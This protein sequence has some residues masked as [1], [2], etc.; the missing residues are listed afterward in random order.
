MTPFI[1][2]GSKTW[3]QDEP[4]R[5]D[6]WDLYWR[7]R[8]L[9]LA[10]RLDNQERI[11]IEL[12]YLAPEF[13]DDD[14]T[15][16][17]FFRARDYSPTS[18]SLNLCLL[19]IIARD[20][21]GPSAIASGD[22][23]SLLWQLDDGSTVQ[24]LAQLDVV[25]GSSSEEGD[26]FWYVWSSGSKPATPLFTMLDDGS[27]GVLKASPAYEV[28]ITGDFNADEYDNI[29]GWFL[30][31][32]GVIQT[33]V[34]AE[35]DSQWE[36]EI[37]TGTAP[38]QATNPAPGPNDNLNCDYLDGEDEWPGAG[39]DD[40]S[41]SPVTVGTSATSVASVTTTKAGWH[42][43]AGEVS[44]D[45]DSG[46]EDQLFTL[47]C[48]GLEELSVLAKTDGQV[49]QFH[50]S[51]WYEATSSEALTLTIKKAGGSGSTEAEGSLIADW[52][53]K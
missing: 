25:R 7:Q 28:D 2:P 50:V 18:Q 8:I 51:G 40:V 19:K 15:D 47:E 29:D 49:W 12:P 36:S 53:G 10:G 33:D 5:F 39:E 37:T 35:V 13:G 42:E 14:E 24:T 22:T 16:Q 32:A 11:E 34:R 20:D 6:D 9:Y 45:F 21:S 26:L 48:T 23:V 1:W 4:V 30:E 3:V 17:V 44:V 52:C 43:I 31:S 38:L 41:G 27:I 46:D